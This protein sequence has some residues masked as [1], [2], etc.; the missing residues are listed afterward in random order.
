[1]GCITTPL[2][3]DGWL[4]RTK[5]AVM[6][7]NAPRLA[8]WLTVS[9]VVGADACPVCDSPT[10]AQVRQSIFNADLLRNLVSIA[11]PFPILG[12]IAAWIHFGGR[13]PLETVPRPK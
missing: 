11:A 7:V 6:R 13:K 8:V 1:M 3:F 10:G 5:L 2:R 9:L 4:S 12:A